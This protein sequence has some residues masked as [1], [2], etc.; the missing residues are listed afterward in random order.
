MENLKKL[1]RE[2]VKNKKIDRLLRTAYYRFNMLKETIKPHVIIPHVPF[3]HYYSPIPSKSDIEIFDFSRLASITEVEGVD[4]NTQEQLELLDK[5]EPFYQELPFSDHKKE[6]LRYYYS[7]GFFSYSD[8]IGLY[9]MLRH[10]KPNRVIEAGSGFSS[11]VTLDTNELFFNNKINCTFIE[12]YP[13]R[14]K[15]LLKKSDKSSVTILEKKL[16]DIPLNLFKELKPNDILFIDS[17][18]VSKF[19]SD[20]NYILH[21]ILP[22]LEKGVYIHFHDIFYPFEYPREWLLGGYAWN[23]DYILRA[24]LEY[25]DVFKIILFNNYLGK[26]YGKTIKERFPLMYKNIGGSIW[27]KKT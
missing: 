3:G 2:I 19:N 7:N 13:E 27:I 12:P 1:Y 16:Q 23:E 5:F 22:A 21:T 24:F 14:L 20:V 11:S 18:H 26:V 4:L 8:A 17:T 6:N 15:S 25:N 9:C 10:L